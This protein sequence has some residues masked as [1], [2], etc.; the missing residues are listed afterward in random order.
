VNGITYNSSAGNAFVTNL[1]L[2][3]TTPNGL[4]DTAAGFFNILDSIIFGFSQPLFAFGIDLNTFAATPAAYTATTSNGDVALSVFDP[5]PGLS[6]GQFV[7][8]VSDLPF[9]SVTIATGANSDAFTLDT[10]RAVAVPEPES[11]SQF[12]LGLIGMGIMRRFSQRGSA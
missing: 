2:S 4:G 1:F 11:I 12:M 10:L 8:F 9:V 6:T 3:S 5:F 7:G